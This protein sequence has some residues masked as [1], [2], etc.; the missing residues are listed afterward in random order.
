MNVISRQPSEAQ[1]NRLTALARLPIFLDLHDKPAVL[2]GGS[3]GAA[4]KAEL[5]AAAGAHVRI[6]AKE[7]SADMAHLLERGAAAGRL[8]HIARAWQS[9]DLQDAAI[10]IA[11]CESEEEARAFQDLSDMLHAALRDVEKMQGRLLN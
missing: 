7:L 4:W 1:P 9:S 2:A 6:Y 10:G 8:T 3:A 11:D 5:L